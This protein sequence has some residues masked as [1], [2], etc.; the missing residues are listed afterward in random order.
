MRAGIARLP[1]LCIVHRVTECF[2]PRNHHDHD[3]VQAQ[4]LILWR[5]KELTSLNALSSCSVAEMGIFIVALVE[6][7][8]FFL[9]PMLDHL[10]IMIYGRSEY[11]RELRSVTSVKE[12]LTARRNWCQCFFFVPL[13]ISLTF[14][15][16]V[17]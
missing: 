12:N 16:P 8:S 7:E 5:R 4:G 9:Q 10:A 1:N 17:C 15:G 11:R 3:A 14:W 2:Y 13:I 6:L